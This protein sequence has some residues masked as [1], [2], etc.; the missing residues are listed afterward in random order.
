MLPLLQ[1]LHL[2]AAKRGDGLRPEFLRMQSEAAQSVT[3]P[4]VQTQLSTLPDN[5]VIPAQCISELQSV[6]PPTSRR[7]RGL[8][9]HTGWER[10]ADE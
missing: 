8:S 4:R 3:F 1:I 9:R 6:E 7:P 10:Q 5:R 2:I